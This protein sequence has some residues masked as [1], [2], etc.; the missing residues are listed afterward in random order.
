M[1]L[2]VLLYELYDYTPL[3]LVRD[4]LK[5]LFCCAL[6]YELSKESAVLH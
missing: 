3:A 4:L 5:N 1:S 6:F 2:S